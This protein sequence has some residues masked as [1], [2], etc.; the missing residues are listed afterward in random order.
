M[1]FYPC[2]LSDAMRSTS[3]LNSLGYFISSRSEFSR[4]RCSAFFFLRFH[5][6]GHSP[7]PDTPSVLPCSKSYEHR[8]PVGSFHSGSHFLHA[9][10]RTVHSHKR[11]HR[12][13]HF[14]YSLLF[15]RWRTIVCTV[16]FCFYPF[17]FF[18][19]K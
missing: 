9:H 2:Q 12:S 14:V 18:W 4:C 1:Y 10:S 3:W 13:C 11:I 15:I 19:Q 6:P 16:I 17:R 5:I 8:K 7:K